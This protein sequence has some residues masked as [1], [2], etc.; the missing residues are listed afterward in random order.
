MWVVRRL[1]LLGASEQDLLTVLRAQVLSVLHFASPAWS[2]LITA[3][4][5]KQIESVLR[6]GLYLV[7]GARYES[8]SW[9]LS[10]ANISS[11]QDQRS[12][13]FLRF[14]NNCIK[15]PK[16]N[17]WFVKNDN[18]YSVSTRQQKS[19]FK[20]IPTRTKAYERSAIPQMVKLAN[21][22]KVDPKTRLVLNSG[23]VI[24]I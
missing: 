6:T 24:V 7:Y 23:Q 19:R 12:S 22:Q 20:P 10:E 2:T 8:F 1:K 13:M 3:Q 5:N 21:S 11:L 15:N 17:K 18:Q 4:E 14:T 9:A 16:F